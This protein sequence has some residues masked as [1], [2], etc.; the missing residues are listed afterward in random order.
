MTTQLQRPKWD[1][2]MQEKLVQVVAKI[3][4]DW[5]KEFDIQDSI[6]EVREVMEHTWRE[7]GYELAKRFERKM[8][9]Q[10]DSILV[11]DLDNVSWETDKILKERTA[12]WV[13][14]ENIA[15]EYSVGTRVI[16][17]HGNK[18]EEGE[19]VSMKEEEARYV[20]CFDSEKSKREG[21]IGTYVNYED[22]RAV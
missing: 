8:Y 21:Y 17:K 14:E 13:K 20:V 18:E 7:D 16:G 10:P 15:P 12:Q 1:E 19:V 9:I 2:A 3:L 4:Y 5:D 22:T 11:S 6:K